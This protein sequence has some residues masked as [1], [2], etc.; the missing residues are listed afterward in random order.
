MTV[1]GF[2]WLLAVIIGPE[3]ALCFTTIVLILG[4][5]LFAIMERMSVKMSMWSFEFSIHSDFRPEAAVSE[6]AFQS[7]LESFQLLFVSNRKDLS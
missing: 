6:K 2:V 5:A 3:T 1:F 7:D 4:M